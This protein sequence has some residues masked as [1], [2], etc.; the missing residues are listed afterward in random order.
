MANLRRQAS[1][2]A[3]PLARKASNGIG[4]WRIQG[5]FGERKSGTPLSVE[6]PA[7]VNPTTL[8]ASRTRATSRAMGSVSVMP[9][10]WGFRASLVIAGAAGDLADRYRAGTPG[11]VSRHSLPYIGP[12]NAPSPQAVAAQRWDAIDVAR[13]VAIAA[14]A[15]YHFS[16]DLSY[17]RL[18]PT[19]IIG[20]PAW[21]WFARSIAG[22]F[23]ALAG[24]G[25]VLAHAGGFR[26]IAFLKRLARIGGAALAV[27]V[28]TLFAFPESYIFFGIL[29]CIAVGSVLAL[30]LL[31]LSSWSIL[32]FAALCLV[33]PRIVTNPAFDHPMLEWLGLGEQDPVTND[34]VPLL[35]WF[36]LILLGIAIGRILLKRGA[37][38]ALARWHA[39]HAVAGA[40]AWMGRKSLPIYLFHQPVL[41]AVLYGVLQLTGPHP[42]AV[43]VAQCRAGCLQ[44][45]GNPQ[46]C[47]AF[48]PCIAD[49]LKES[50]DFDRILADERDAASDPRVSQA[51][52]ECL[53]RGSE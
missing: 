53:R 43:F 3:S 52:Q 24:V 35:P 47:R 48:C 17:L 25:L 30:P 33:A 37:A 15:V 29:H 41:L 1:Q 31:R 42:T 39:D 38:M 32:V 20:D 5:E 44:Q 18:I 45:S 40:F 16:W 4:L 50:G 7:P 22:S 28:V 6:M 26:H 2:R 9:T 46:M 11:L 8:R 51:A 27:T 23:L 36:G 21:N 14:M 49:R 10:I 12:V 19:T 34:Y 13:G